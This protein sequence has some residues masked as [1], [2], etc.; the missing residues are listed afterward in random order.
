[1]Q[2]KNVLKTMI[3]NYKAL[4]YK[5]Y[6]EIKEYN[7]YILSNCNGLL[8]NYCYNYWEPI[9]EVYML[10]DMCNGSLLGDN[11]YL[12]QFGYVSIKS[13]N[14]FE[15]VFK[16][17]GAFF[18]KCKKIGKTRLHNMNL[19]SL[20]ILLKNVLEVYENIKLIRNHIYIR[21]IDLKAYLKL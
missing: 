20:I 2:T 16:V 19:F 1:M 4:I 8:L 12:N 14:Y 15:C 5:V 21:K 11:I 3:Y 7:D 13:F 9:I 10:C 18:N 17:Y 6:L